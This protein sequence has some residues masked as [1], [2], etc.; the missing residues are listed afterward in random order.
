[1]KTPA[2]PPLAVVVVSVILVAEALL[3]TG[4][5]GYL[6]YASAT[7][8]ADSSA[9]A[10]GL[11]VMAALATIWVA[12]TAISFIRGK[13]GSRGP[14]IVWQ[15]LQGAVGIASNQG[16]FARPDIGSGLLIPAIL[17]V[18]LLLFSKPVSRHLGAENN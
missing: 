2:F 10:L 13:A 12:I 16:L 11:V 15:V 18:V 4:L 8:Q 9:S 3:L 7:N 17:V 1:M 6:A 5:F 14:A